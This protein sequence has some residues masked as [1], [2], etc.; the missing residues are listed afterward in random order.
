M[1][2][3]DCNHEAT[4]VTNTGRHICIDC[5]CRRGIVFAT[6]LKEKKDGE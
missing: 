6:P 3:E 5:L 1:K 4:H 2:T